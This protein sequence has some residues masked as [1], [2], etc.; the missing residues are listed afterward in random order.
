MA[1]YIE[2]EAVLDAVFELPP[3]MDEQGYGWV[4]RGG[5][6]QTIRD[7]PA[8]DV[9]PVVRCKD[10]LHSKLN[11]IDNES[12]ICKLSGHLFAPNFYCASGGRM[13]GGT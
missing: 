8:A 11:E 5:L 13:D 12:Y 4:A 1:E 3:K 10:C 2:R 7:F 6:Y 9:V